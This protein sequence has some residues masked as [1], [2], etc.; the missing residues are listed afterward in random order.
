M[1]ALLCAQH[2]VESPIASVAGCLEACSMFTPMTE[3]FPPNPPGPNPMELSPSSMSFSICAALGLGLCDPT[4]LKR[5]FLESFAAT[6]E[7]PAI[8]MPTRPWFATGAQRP[9]YSAM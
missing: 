3:S 1:P 6:S 7:E 4:C 8:P 2:A 5:A 9:A